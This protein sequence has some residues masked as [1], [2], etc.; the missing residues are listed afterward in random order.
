M[1]VSSYD[2][3]F[4]DSKGNEIPAVHCANIHFKTGELI[5]VEIGQNTGEEFVHWVAR[6][7]TDIEW[8]DKGITVYTDVMPGAMSEYNKLEKK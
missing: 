8:S 3:K 4:V 2:S 5:Y 1:I 6:I 7:V